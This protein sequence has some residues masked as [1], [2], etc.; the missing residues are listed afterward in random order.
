MMKSPYL[1]TPIDLADGEHSCWSDPP[2]PLFKVRGPNY[3]KDGL[4]M[5]SID[6]VL[7]LSAFEFLSISHLRPMQGYLPL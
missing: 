5:P 7:K 3:F 2:G 6:S 4:K 1:F